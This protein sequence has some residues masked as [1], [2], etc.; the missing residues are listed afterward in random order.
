M[1]F[2]WK[3]LSSLNIIKFDRSLSNTLKIVFD[4]KKNSKCCQRCLKFLTMKSVLKCVFD[5]DRSICNR[6]ATLN[7]SCLVVRL[8]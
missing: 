4:K 8:S 6:C 5:V 7:A 3:S 2:V 1:S